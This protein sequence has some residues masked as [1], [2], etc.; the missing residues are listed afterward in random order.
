MSSYE[1][2]DVPE[3]EDSKI[4]QTDAEAV[5]DGPTPLGEIRKIAHIVF[6]VLWA[7]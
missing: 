2:E 3:E 6:V 1:E 5:D 7:R 4:I